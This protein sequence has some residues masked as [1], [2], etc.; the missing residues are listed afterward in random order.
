M[1][2]PTNMA[3]QHDVRLQA[4]Q[5]ALQAGD[6]ASAVSL[7]RAALSDG[8]VHPLL[9]NLRALAF[10]REGRE[11]E[12]LNDLLQ[13]RELAPQDPAILNALGLAFARQNRLLEAVS[14]F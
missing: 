1:P 5:R 4:V 9:L 12:A 13:A 6:T 11:Q 7:A 8:V 2:E 14:A 3:G 10:E